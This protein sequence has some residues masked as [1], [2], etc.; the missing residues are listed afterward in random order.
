[1]KAKTHYY[2]R[3]LTALAASAFLLI[4][5]DAFMFDILAILCVVVGIQQ[6]LKARK[7]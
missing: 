3:F 4:F 5:G 1:M 6:L 7:T 2:L